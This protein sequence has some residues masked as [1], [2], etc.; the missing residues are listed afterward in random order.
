MIS[1]YRKAESL[2]NHAQYLGAP[3]SEFSIPLTAREAFE[4]LEDM[5]NNFYMQG[6][7]P[8]FDDDLKECKRT[9]NPWPMIVGTYVMGMETIP[10]QG[11]MQ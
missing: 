5:Q 7:C 6:G 8:E 4:L 1:A 9:N 11:E 3:L 10:M 2:R